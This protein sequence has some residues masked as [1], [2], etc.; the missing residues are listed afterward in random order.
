MNE[1]SKNQCIGGNCWSLFL[2]KFAELLND[3]HCIMGKI[4]ID[5][6]LFDVDPVVL[7]QVIHCMSS[8]VYHGKG[9]VE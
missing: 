7:C 1:L 3:Q 9:A 4:P 6:E 8:M 2:S 5:A